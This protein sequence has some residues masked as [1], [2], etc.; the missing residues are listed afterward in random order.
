MSDGGL[1]ATGSAIEL[2]SV[3][4]SDG[5]VIRVGRATDSYHRVGKGDLFV[6]LFTPE[7][8]FAMHAP[9]KPGPEMKGAIGPASPGARQRTMRWGLVAERNGGEQRA[10]TSTFDIS[11]PEGVIWIELPTA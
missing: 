7:G 9:L 2:A 8:A 10:G 3:T 1:F 11:V 4:L 5:V 6:E